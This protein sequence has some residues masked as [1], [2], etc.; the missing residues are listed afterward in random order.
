[1]TAKKGGEIMP[2]VK[3]IPQKLKRKKA[4]RVVAYARVSC[5]KNQMIKSLWQQGYRQ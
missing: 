2:N 4:V 3:V 1:M 5:P